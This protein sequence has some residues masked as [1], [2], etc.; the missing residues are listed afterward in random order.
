MHDI[1]FLL[2]RAVGGNSLRIYE[3]RI[4]GALE[5]VAGLPIYGDCIQ[6]HDFSP[7]S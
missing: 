7:S 6:V 4:D 1:F 2:F 3:L 5:R